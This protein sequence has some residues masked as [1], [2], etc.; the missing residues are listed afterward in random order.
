MKEADKLLAR[1]ELRSNIAELNEEDQFLD[2]VEVVKKLL[3]ERYD[4]AAKEKEISNVM[5]KDFNMSYK[6]IKSIAV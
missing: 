1:Q 5:K 2:S 3:Q 6:K 4:M